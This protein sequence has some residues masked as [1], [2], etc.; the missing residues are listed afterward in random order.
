MKKTK[1]LPICFLALILS[2]GNLL[3]DRSGRNYVSA[4]QTNMATSSQGYCSIRTLKG[5]YSYTVTGYDQNSPYAES[6]LETYDGRGNIV[7][8]GSDSADSNNS[9]F[10]GT[11][12]VN[13]DC[14]GT[15]DYGDNIVYNI[16][17]R[18][19]GAGFTFLDKTPGS[20]LTGDEKKISSKL[21]LK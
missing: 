11:Y 20:V 13:S 8:L 1:I 19:D 15:V 4:L 14:T 16:Y 6:G 12:T 2:S 21:I 17:V 5:T 10:R 18:T 9:G 3:A 7:G